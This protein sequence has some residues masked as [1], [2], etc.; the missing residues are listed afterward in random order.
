MPKSNH[1]SV[2]ITISLLVLTIVLA[3][4]S[5][6]SLAR[7]AE[8]LVQVHI[9]FPPDECARAGEA[10]FGSRLAV[11]DVDGD[12][13]LDL[14]VT[15]G[16]NQG[17]L[18]L[19]GSS[20]YGLDK[21]PWA[22]LAVPAD[23]VTA[24][25]F[26]GDGYGDVVA[27][28][29][30]DLSIFFGGPDRTTFGQDSWQT[31][32]RVDGRITSVA[33]LG[34]VDGD[35]TEDIVVGFDNLNS[36]TLVHGHKHPQ[37]P[38]HDPV[39]V[40]LK[41]FTNAKGHAGDVNGDGFFDV[42]RTVPAI[43]GVTATAEV[44]LG[45]SNDM[46]DPNR[47]EA[48]PAW[49]LQNIEAETSFGFG[50]MSG[51]AGDINNDGFGDIAITDPYYD[52]NPNSDV[53]WRGRVYFWYGGPP[54]AEDRSGLGTN[55]TP[56]TA[57][58][59]KSGDAPNSANR[60][61]VAG[62]FN[63]DDFS[64][65]AIGDGA[66]ASVTCGVEQTGMV[67][68]YHSGLGPDDRDSDGIKNEYDNCPFTPNP[69]QEDR[70]GDGVGDV[71][72]NCVDTPNSAQTDSDDDGRGD[73]CD[74]CPGDPNDDQDGDLICAG[75]GFSDPMAGDNDN[76]P[77]VA[78]PDQIDFDNDGFGD[79]CDNCRTVPNS[80]QINSDD[81]SFGDACDNCP[82]TA[83]DDQIDEDGDDVGDAC[84]NCL[85]EPNPRTSWID[86][87]GVAHN[88]EQ[89]DADLDGVGDACDNCAIDPNADQLDDDGDQ[90][91]NVCDNCVSQPN[92]LQSDRDF[93]G[94]GDV[95]DACK[96]DPD[97][98]IDHDA[99]CGDV[100]NCPA[101]YNASQVDSDGDGRGDHC[102]IDL[103]LGR[104][105][106]TQAVQS[107]DNSIP[108]VLGKPTWVR[109]QVGVGGTPGPV[110]NVTAKMIGFPPGRPKEEILPDPPVI[111]A[112]KYPDRG[113]IKQSF[114]FRLPESWYDPHSKTVVFNVVVNPDRTV[115]EVDYF[116]NTANL[117][118][119]AFN[120]QDP[121]NV[122]V[123]PY[124]AGPNVFID[125]VGPCLAPDSQ[126]IED[127]IAWAKKVYPVPRVNVRVLNERNFA[128]D[129]T[130]RFRTGARLMN[131]LFWLNLFSNDPLPRM[132][133]FGLVCEEL[134][135]TS[136]TQGILEGGGQL[137][138]GWGDQ[139]WAVREDSFNFTLKVSNT[140]TISG[141]EAMAHEL[142]HT[143]LGNG[144]SE[145]DK[146]FW[147]SHVR[148]NCGANGPFFDKY[149]ST[150]PFPGMIDEYG[151]DGKTVY[152]PDKYFDMMTYSPC[153]GAPG[154]G[155]WIS[156]FTYKLLFGEFR[157][158]FPRTN[159]E[160]EPLGEETLG[161]YL[162]VSAVVDAQDQ[163]QS[164]RSGVISLPEGTH[165]DPGEGPFS[166]ELWDDNSVPLFVRSFEPTPFEPVDGSDPEYWFAE[167]IPFDQSTVLIV[168]KENGQI[169]GNYPVSENAPQVTVISPNGG[170]S[171][172]GKQSITWTA[173]DQDGDALTYEV[174]YS[175]DG[176]ETWTAIASE[177]ADITYMWDTGQVAGSNHALIKVMANDGVNYGQDESDGSFS[178]P[179]K[180]PAAFV[181]SP[182][183]GE[184]FYLDQPVTLE[185]DGLDPEDIELSAEQFSWI[186]DLDGDL[187]SGENL[188]FV[189]LSP[190]DHT[191]TLSVEDSDGN[192]G[193][194][195][196]S[197]TVLN[198]K[199]SDGDD[200]G[201]QTDNCPRVY[202]PLQEDGD[203]DGS[204]DACDD[205]D[206]D[207]D[208]FPD[209]YDNCASVP[210]DQS[211]I[212]LDG[213][214]DVCDDS[215]DRYWVYLP[216]V[217]R[218]FTNGES[219]FGAR[220]MSP[221]K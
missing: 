181:L 185:G 61:F 182:A 160:Y 50:L 169:L 11:G 6:V 188:S 131:D 34:D 202:N 29:R 58:I 184:V 163:I 157:S 173:E 153:V 39:I 172:D 134:E 57:D 107:F 113:D 150:S 97:N 126:D 49:S 30:G 12:S 100:D 5:R 1:P 167:E 159:S 42:I 74:A 137:G 95:C 135:P 199:D 43:G 84:D 154:T 91:G 116:N 208:G 203:G 75:D 48:A 170:E 204:G 27:V 151:F 162:V 10:T 54:T 76:C 16:V 47:V 210:N 24:T 21:G 79:A 213:I 214:G 141:G 3:L 161:E 65:V 98:D 25:D 18:Y 15:E 171:L 8:D 36:A 59:I 209:Y 73:A 51:S 89:I 192:V 146:L 55:Q 92:P 193:M 93:D 168:L 212:D 82:E 4:F 155:Q 53:G 22:T 221:A 60:Y 102:S 142:G 205:D 194:A 86:I 83:N 104:F 148:D 101:I 96:L 207:G 138:M 217:S 38:P 189:T 7:P 140:L 219:Y 176:G 88:D 179:T 26:N 32:L 206:A 149:P 105:E 191:I 200:V 115:E 122:R 139:A 68:V 106:V 77:L 44:Y 186:S 120:E 62:D 218:R 174:L 14:I 220:P 125:G 190:G 110:K 119:R 112:F 133:Y 197:I 143:F 40:D 19:Y 117:T 41:I 67:M 147:P 175:T 152:T 111:T 17:L 145:P 37:E 35:G 124:R 158:T 103:W 33:R 132:K 20:L 166:L 128:G 164:W 108:L 129:P 13:F 156:S 72:D 64:D 2:F 80:G 81:D 178:V 211:D 198:D 71:C 87:H 31:T 130:K 63:R 118:T 90:V 201:D 52:G 70:D 216:V 127:T 109:I 114:N 56:L 123:V 144:D 45:I 28:F 136:G 180:P 177:L 183:A 69:G 195:A 121:M 94:L 187:G 196:V 165:D 215:L 23:D 78:N 9:L 46:D 66:G 85:N 99:V